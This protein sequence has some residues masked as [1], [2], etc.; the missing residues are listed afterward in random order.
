[1]RHGIAQ[2]FRR[3]SGTDTF[4]DWLRV[5]SEAANSLSTNKHDHDDT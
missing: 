3:V 1:M 4:V 5:G 2:Q